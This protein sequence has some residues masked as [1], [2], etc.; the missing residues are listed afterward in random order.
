N[1][2]VGTTLRPSCSP[3]L[4]AQTKL[5][6][7]RITKPTVVYQTL[8]SLLN[9][10]I[11]FLVAVILCFIFVPH[12]QV[13]T[14]IVLAFGL[15]ASI[16]LFYIAVLYAQE[17][18]HVRFDAQNKLLVIQRGSTC[19]KRTVIHQSAVTTTQI[20][21]GP[22]LNK[23]GLAKIRLKGCRKLPVIPPISL[24]EAR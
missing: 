19:S 10:G 9:A 22:I 17:M 6:D 11:R 13:A 15:V 4:G 23:R 14:A 16:A 2:R 21:R 24:S 3:T 8:Q 1:R 18:K 5:V 7:V 12:Q 20:H